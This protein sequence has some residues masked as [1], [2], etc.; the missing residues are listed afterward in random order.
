[1]I[2]FFLLHPAYDALHGIRPQHVFSQ[3]AE[4]AAFFEERGA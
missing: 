3:G 1:M 2:E 4:A